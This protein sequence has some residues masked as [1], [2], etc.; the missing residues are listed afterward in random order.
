ME[1]LYKTLGNAKCIEL[2]KK[3]RTFWERNP[4]HG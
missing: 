2:S 4:S 3:S 1:E